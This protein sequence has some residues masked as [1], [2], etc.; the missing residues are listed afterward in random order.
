MHHGAPDDLFVFCLGFLG[1]AAKGG[2]RRCCGGDFFVWDSAGPGTG[3]LVKVNH[4]ALVMLCAR[5]SW[6]VHSCRAST[7]DAHEEVVFCDA[8]LLKFH[9]YVVGVNLHDVW[10]DSGFHSPRGKS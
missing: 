10:C 4:V 3:S 5:S 6:F 9:V 2:S 8:C 1:V 7:A